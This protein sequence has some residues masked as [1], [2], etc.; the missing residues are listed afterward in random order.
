MP[1]SLTLKEAEGV[2]CRHGYTVENIS[3][4]TGVSM[5]ALNRGQKYRSQGQCNCM[6]NK[7]AAWTWDDPETKET[8]YCGAEIISLH[9]MVNAE[10][11]PLASR[12][13]VEEKEDKNNGAD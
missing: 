4:S 6:G 9:E 3:L 12:K 7:C 13:P 8:G 11:K 5:A 1:Q 10:G 2:W